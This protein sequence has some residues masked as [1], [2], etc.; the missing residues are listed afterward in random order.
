MSER[1]ERSI[2]AVV[3][4]IGSNVDRIVRA[5][6]GLAVAELR[7]QVEAVRNVS[8]IL[9]AG[10]VAAV[11]AA[12]FLLLGAMFALARLMPLWLAALVVAALSGALAAALLIR[13]RAQVDGRLAP[14]PQ[15]ILPGPTGVS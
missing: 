15:Q 11:L 1:G 6:M 8:G 2:G 7:L 12:A 9:V 3:R 13:F 14:K 10:V 5:E 4:D